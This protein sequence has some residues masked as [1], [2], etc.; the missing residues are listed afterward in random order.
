MEIFV[1]VDGLLREYNSI[2]EGWRYCGGGG[3]LF[4][5]LHV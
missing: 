3:K 5:P 2:I 1:V 4:Q